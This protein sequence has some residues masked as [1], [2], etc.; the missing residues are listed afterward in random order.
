M[1]ITSKHVSRQLRAD[2]RASITAKCKL[3]ESW[4][5]SGLPSKENPQKDNDES[6]LKLEWFPTSLRAFCAWDGSQNSPTLRKSFACIRRNA[7]ETLKSDETTCLKVLALI[8][9]L[10]RQSKVLLRNAEPGR[11]ARE[12]E[13]L[14]LLERQKRY[15]ALLGY[16]AAR[17]RSRELDAALAKEKRAHQE[18]IKQY[19]QQIEVKNEEIVELH[20]RVARLTADMRKVAPIRRVR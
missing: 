11:R 4:S 3:L 20:D 19:E 2:A 18:T 6:H 9:T 1:T 17:R 14:A 5:R 16:R 12:S 10:K 7:F 8:E 15:G 13:Q